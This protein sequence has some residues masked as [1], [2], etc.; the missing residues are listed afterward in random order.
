MILRDILYTMVPRQIIDRP[1]KGFG[2]PVGQWF[3]GELR[4]LFLDIVTKERLRELVP[5]LRAEKFI[6]YRDNLLQQRTPTLTGDAF[7]KVF[8]YLYWYGHQCPK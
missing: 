4:D 5:E 1:K 7:F 2:A 3:K 8:T 6:E